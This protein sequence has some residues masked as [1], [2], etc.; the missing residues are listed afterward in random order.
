MEDADE[1]DGDRDPQADM[2]AKYDACL[3]GPREAHEHP[4]LSVHFLKKF[5]TIIRRR[6][7]WAACSGSCT[8]SSCAFVPCS[9]GHT[10]ALEDTA[11]EGV[12]GS[13]QHADEKRASQP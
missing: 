11:W 3:H 10:P 1:E 9:I 2:Y 7:R 5:L 13:R 6:A 12:S 8:R 4:P